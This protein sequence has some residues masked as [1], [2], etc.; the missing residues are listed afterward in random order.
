VRGLFNHDPNFILGRST[1][2]TLALSDDERPALRHLAPDT[3]TIRDLVIAPM[4]RGDINQSRLRSRLPVM[5]TT[6]TRMK[7]ALLFVKSA[8]FP[9]CTMSRR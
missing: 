8:S 6:G 1:S 3:P 5:V 2:G 7:K 4:V 9:V